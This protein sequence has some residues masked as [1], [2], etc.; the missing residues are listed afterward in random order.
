MVQIRVSPQ[1]IFRFLGSAWTRIVETPSRALKLLRMFLCLEIY[2]ERFPFSQS[3]MFN[4]DRERL[5]SNQ[6]LGRR[7]HFVKLK[8]SVVHFHVSSCK[9][10]NKCVKSEILIIRD[11]FTKHPH[12]YLPAKTVENGS[13]LWA[14]NSPNHQRSEEMIFQPKRITLWA[15]NQILAKTL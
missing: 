5:S 6:N 14:L 9:Y 1:T 11:L 12:K 2:R 10:S 7:I 4:K 15:L 8:F 3:A 13:T